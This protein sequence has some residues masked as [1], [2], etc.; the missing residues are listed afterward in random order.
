MKKILLSVLMLSV[1]VLG[2][3]MASAVDWDLLEIKNI[4]LNGVDQ[5]TVAP[6]EIIAASVQV[7]NDGE[8]DFFCH[9]WSSTQYTIEGYSPICINVP[10]PDTYCGIHTRGFQITAPSAEGTYDFEVK[11]Y[12]QE[13]CVD[14][15]DDSMLIE[16]IIVVEPAICGDG[17]MNQQSEDCDDGNQVQWDGCT[18]CEQ[19]EIVVNSATEML[20]ATSDG[21]ISFAF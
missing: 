11:V 3:G 4:D 14:Y 2:M 20:P 7:Q 15:E 8:F 9:K 12:E 10:E 19:T 18:A 6:S 21:E 17:E 1:L 13:N 5:V 16:G